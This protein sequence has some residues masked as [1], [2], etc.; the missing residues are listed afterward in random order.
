MSE[1]DILVEVS[2]LKTHFFTDEGVVKAVDGVDLK[3]RRGQT[4]CI[5]GESGCGKSMTARSIMQIVRPPGKI[6][7]GAM[8]YHR[9]GPEGTAAVDLAQLDPLG[10]RMR[11]IRG[12]EI[13][14]I[15][16]EP[17][18]S[19]SP[20]HTIGNQ[21]IEAI[22]LHNDINQKEARN[23]AI[24]ML[25]KV[26]LPKPADRLD[27]YPFEL[28]GGMRQRAMIA[29][30]LSCN[31]AL[32][33]A[34]EPT[35]ALD[36]TTQANILDLIQELQDEYGMAVMFITHDLGIVAEIADDLAVMYLGQI[37]E[38]GDVRAIFHEPQH[39]YT[40]ALLSS[41]PRLSTNTRR[42]LEGGATPRMVAIHGMVPHPFARP[43]G[44]QFHPRCDY[45]LDGLC[46]VKAPENVALDESRHVRCLLY[47]DGVDIPLN[48]I[49]LVDERRAK[50]RAEASAV[51]AGTD[52]SG[53]KRPLLEAC[54]LQMY[55]PIQKGL[56]RRV[57]GHVRAVDGVDF[58]IHEGETLGLVGESGCGKTT[59]GRC[60]IQVLRP[61]GGQVIYTNGKA[62]NLTTKRTQAALLPFLREIR[63]IFQDPYSS[64]NP[65]MSVLEIVGEPLRNHGIASGSEL[66][67]R[68]ADLLRRVGLRA[69][70]MQRY[71]H[72][73]SGGERQR[74]GVARALA[75]N[76]RLVIADEAV[77]ALDVSVQAQIL[78]LLQDLRDD[79]GLTYLFISHDLSVVEQIS[80]RVAVM[81]VGRIVELARS[82][83]IFAAPRHPYTEALLSAVPIPDPAKRES[84]ARIRL[85]GEVADPA[86][87]PSGCYFHPRCRFAEERCRSETPVLR[88]IGDGRFA[89]CHFAEDLNLAGVVET[90]EY[91]S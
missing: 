58:T 54:N 70:Y 65:R 84:K 3:I 89:A 23:R 25:E 79:Y 8:L 27:A 38:D 40:R 36:V 59:L 74:I 57:V 17:M 75:L 2:G 85:T 55:F 82:E 48:H 29:M 6:V 80:D 20:V 72:A 35:T 1:S 66:E 9:R 12:R 91:A 44:C 46:N 19:L 43:K 50:A 53:E 90:R 26:G 34:D 87:P 4:L 13:S 14:M 61:T 37:V 78:N 60:L 10:A 88:D 30:A 63:M 52:A 39:P 83:Q 28:S 86:N 16:Q 11:A 21:I 24:E 76:P 42:R 71:P 22:R 33:I 32:L 5:V 18:T 77:S 64:L 68:V 62:V 49:Q 67:D 73:F 81:Y 15:F 47:A 69:E 45:A 7:E 51:V 31:P 41:I 56:L